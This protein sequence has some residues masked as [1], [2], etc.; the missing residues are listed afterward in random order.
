MCITTNRGTCVCPRTAEDF[1]CD[2]DVEY[3]LCVE[4]SSPA[5]VNMPIP[6]F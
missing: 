4:G 2:K 6:S 1:A 5:G 3:D